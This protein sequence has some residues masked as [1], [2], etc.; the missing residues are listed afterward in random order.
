M[1]YDSV[2]KLNLHSLRHV[3]LKS[4]FPTTFLVAILLAILDAT[5]PPALGQVRTATVTVYVT[6]VQTVPV[7]VPV[8][9]YVTI[10]HVAT[11][12]MTLTTTALSLGTV[13]VLNTTSLW[14]TVTT[15]AGGILG[16]MTSI[17]GQYSDVALVSV[18][19]LGGV[20]VGLISSLI[21]NKWKYAGAEQDDHL[22]ADLSDIAKAK[23]LEKIAKAQDDLSK[24]KED[25]AKLNN[26]KSHRT[27]QPLDKALRPLKDG[28]DVWKKFKDEI[29]HFLDR[30]KHHRRSWP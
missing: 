22:F 23:D 30:F 16:P 26:A 20:A 21:A 25:K 12:F 14:H 9:A 17:F 1:Q 5:M 18:G 13:T 10:A 19:A 29:D 4:Y 7:Y 24:L 27:V 15:A 8:T 6:V 2:D 3:L 28:E 11:S